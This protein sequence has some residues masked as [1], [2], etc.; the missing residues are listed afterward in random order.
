MGKK[1]LILILMLL[2]G[3]III[4]GALFTAYS[5][6]FNVKVKVLNLNVSGIIFG[7]LILYFGI[8]YIPKLFKLKKQIEKPNMKFSWSNFQILK[9]GRSK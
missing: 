3:L 6:Y 5:A 1:F 9:R 2:D 8:R 4:S 7:L